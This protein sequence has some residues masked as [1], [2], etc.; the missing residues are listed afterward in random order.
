M[1]PDI[2]SLAIARDFDT[3]ALVLRTGFASGATVGVDCI[4]IQS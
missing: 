3:R 1:E 2:L 4:L